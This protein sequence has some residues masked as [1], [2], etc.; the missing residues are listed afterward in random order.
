[1]TLPWEDD[2]FQKD[3]TNTCDALLNHIKQQQDALPVALV[4]SYQSLSHKDAEHSSK[5]NALDLFYNAIDHLKS[6]APG[7]KPGLFSTAVE[8]ASLRSSQLA[9]SFGVRPP[10]Y[11][12][13]PHVMTYKNGTEAACL[14]ALRLIEAAEA[15]MPK[16]THALRQ[17]MFET[18]AA[19][20]FG[21][22][23]EDDIITEDLKKMFKL[24]GMTEKEHPDPAD[25]LT[26][27][28]QNKLAYDALVKSY[29]EVCA[30]LKQT[31]KDMIPEPPQTR[32]SPKT[33]SR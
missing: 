8:K 19:P 30:E 26:L 5:R 12:D 21:H 16:S 9:A 23:F 31:I 14:Y 18:N 25:T 11:Q 13:M 10:K 1:M 4:T 29:A 33:P 17:G 7:G 15:D 22:G 2:T 24:S 20:A 6:G 27:Q 3:Y 28:R 32:R